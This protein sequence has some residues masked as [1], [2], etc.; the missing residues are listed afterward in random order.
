[1]ETPKEYFDREY[2]TEHISEV[3]DQKDLVSMYGL[4]DEYAQ[5]RV[6]ILPISDVVISEERVELVC[7]CKKYPHVYDYDNKPY[8]SNCNAPWVAS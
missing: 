1:M 4:I 3:I 5:Y 2:G 6:K 8:C 7:D